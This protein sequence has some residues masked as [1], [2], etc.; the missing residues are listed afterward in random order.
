MTYP[1][2]AAEVALTSM[3]AVFDSTILLFPH[4]IGKEVRQKITAVERAI[5]YIRTKDVEPVSADAVAQIAG[6]SA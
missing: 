3:D 4:G 6:M 2:S 5:A 1:T